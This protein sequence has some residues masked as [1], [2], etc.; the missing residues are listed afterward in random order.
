MAYAPIVLF[1]YNRPW[2]LEQ[3]L[4]SLKKNAEAR[5]SELYVFC[6]GPKPYIR[7]KDYL[8]L[9]K[10]AELCSDIEGFKSVKVF[11]S[12]SNKGLQR[13][14]IEGL[15]LVFNM[16]QKAVVLE[17][18]VLVSPYFLKFMN[19]GLEAYKNEKRVLSLGSWNYFYP[20]SVNFFNHMP[21]TIAWATWKDRWE[22]FE[23]DGQKLY[24]QLREKQ[25][26]DR[27]NLDQR[28]NFE[29]MLLKQI[30]G[31]TSSWAIR[32]TALAVLKD[33]LTLYPSQSLSKHIGFG[34]DSTNCE[35]EDYNKNLNLA[36]TP[37]QI[38][39]VPVLEDKASVDAWLKIEQLVKQSS[40][41]MGSLAV[42]Q[43]PLLLRRIWNKGRNVFKRVFRVK[44]AYG[45]FGDYRNW[46]KV[47]SI[48]K[49]YDQSAILEKVKAGLSLVQKGE[50]AYE[51]DGMVFP[52]LEYS[53]QL[54]KVFQHIGQEFNKHLNVLDFGGSL[55]SLY[56]QYREALKEMNL[57]WNVVEQ[58]HFVDCGRKHFEN[59]ELHFYRSISESE[60]SAHSN[61]LLLS[62]V[63]AYLPQP[64]VFLK[65]VQ[66]HD[67]DYIVL[68]RTAFVDGDEDR[69]TL[70]VVP[71]EVYKASYPAWFFCE[72]KL[73]SD[74]QGKYVLISEFPGDIE[75]EYRLNDKRAYWKGMVF[76]RK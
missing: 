4:S 34:N 38:S 59:R 35:E 48:S 64:H 54:L 73:M 46:E 68:Y 2:H 12:E 1:C 31:Q 60:D 74:L 23:P 14:V 25:L 11:R 72:K 16:H 61:I 3:T 6:D 9:L 70:Q 17:D 30:K 71:P 63:L 51:R 53:V 40:L 44:R 8:N 10:V 57:N 13:S 39:P 66:S 76:K 28:F 47:V 20:G 55:G 67:F 41:L 75:T 62:S 21:D 18:D 43:P 52:E 37:V 5:E 69:L 27:F 29:S 33:T 7:H 26:M 32:W 58:A 15:N 56:F 65:S 19:E 42:K 22:W 45:W 50:A 49:G 36:N 24:R